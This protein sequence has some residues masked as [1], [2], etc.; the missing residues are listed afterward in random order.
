MHSRAGPAGCFPA[1]LYVLS[2]PSTAKC[3]NKLGI[4]PRDCMRHRFAIIAHLPIGPTS[5][6][7]LSAHSLQE[8]LTK[9]KLCGS[10]ADW[11]V[12]TR[13]CCLDADLAFAKT[14]HNI[15]RFCTASVVRHRKSVVHMTCLTQRQ[16]SGHRKVVI[17]T[18]GGLHI[19]VRLKTKS[20]ERQH[21]AS[22]ELRTAHLLPLC[23]RA[24]HLPACWWVLV[25]HCKREQHYL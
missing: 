25:V 2:W 8:C 21:I 1:A 24:C 22:A 23:L 3:Q 20:A 19:G 16:T 5:N 14:L 12:K 4:V 10:L 7:V 6:P 18:T 11:Q 17:H 15:T 13:C 9:A